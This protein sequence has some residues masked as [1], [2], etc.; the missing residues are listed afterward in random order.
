VRITVTGASGNLGT[1]VLRA[2]AAELPDAEVVAVARRAPDAD[3]GLAMPAR[4]EWAE[5]DL[6]FDDLTS[7]LDAADAVVHLAWAFHPAHRPDQTWQTNVVG[8]RRLLAASARVGVP[9]VAVASSVAAYSPRRNLDRVDER[10]PTDGTS[11]APYAREKAYVE[12]VLDGFAAENPTVTV[13]RMRP[14]FVFQQ[15]AASEQRRIFAGH[16]APT[17]AALRVAALALP[18]PTGLTLQA[19]HAEDVGGAFVAALGRQQG[20][21]FNLAA[22]D[23]L[24]RSGLGDVFGGHPLPVPAALV[25]VAVWS[26]ATRGRGRSRRRSRSRAHPQTCAAKLGASL[27]ASAHRHASSGFHARLLPADPRLLDALLKM[28][29]LSTERARELLGWRPQHT[30][31]DALRSLRDGL[32][33]KA[34]AP[35]PPLH[36]G[37]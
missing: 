30:A 5:R 17:R 23:V 7:V 14:A 4:T 21:A 2:A 8:T 22:D 25:R 20:G 11:A 29:M 19:V 15:S 10:W 16:L 24:D 27:P 37:A 28:P 9:H 31:A 32:L 36:T 3:T 12:R 18:V 33:N 13:T 6:R 34:G 26:G 35:T 1:A